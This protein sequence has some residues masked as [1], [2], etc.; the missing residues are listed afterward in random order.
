[1]N[2]YHT[3]LIWIQNSKPPLSFLLIV[4]FSIE[5]HEFGQTCRYFILRFYSTTITTSNHH[6]SISLSLTPYTSLIHFPII[7]FRLQHRSFQLHDTN[8][9]NTSVPLSLHQLLTFRPLHIEF[10]S[11]KKVIPDFL[12]LDEWWVFLFYFNF[13]YPCSIKITTTFFLGICEL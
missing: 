2:P 7:I 5:I 12:K 9:N 8:K 6:T 1:M 13:T 11:V 3:H 10:F 4:F